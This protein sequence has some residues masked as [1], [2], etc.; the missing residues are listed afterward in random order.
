MST[1]T[2][3]I[4]SGAVGLV[5][6]TTIALG[7]VAHGAA[8]DTAD[9]QTPSID[10]QN[11]ARDHVLGA[12]TADAASGTTSDGSTQ[13]Q[14]AGGPNPRVL[15][16]DVSGYQPNVDWGS[17]YTKG[18][19]FVFI[20]ATESYNST[21]SSFTSQWK[22]ATNAG[23][24]RGAYHFAD[25]FES[26]GTSQANWFLGHGGAWTPDG[27]TLPP[28][29]DLEKNT[30]L[31][32]GDVSVNTC[33]NL[34]PAQ[35]TAW[36]RDFSNTVLARTGIRPTIYTNPDFWQTCMAGSTSFGANSLFLAHWTYDLNTGP[37]A[38]PASWS[39]YSFWQY[40]DD[41]GSPVFP[42]DQDVFN[43][44]AA[45]L[46]AFA[47]H[48]TPDGNYITALYEDYLKRA[49]APQESAGWQDR[50]A[51]GAPRTAVAAGFVNSD[52]YR[53]QRI[54]AAYQ[55]VLGRSPDAPGRLSWLNAMKSGGIT[56]DDI[57]TSL[58][59]STE[60]FQNH[61]NTN[62]SFVAS[63]YTTLLHRQGTDAD[64]TFWANLIA[65][66][67]RAWVVAQYWDA[68]E[69]ISQRVSA[70]YQL[71]LGRV[72]DAA[73]LQGWVNVALQIGDSGL[74]SG[75]TSSGEYYARSQTRTF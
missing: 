7:G 61:G 28:V 10:A 67:G 51:A 24:L 36:A 47:R 50:L 70:M 49:P 13:A 38:L 37:G 35:L 27:K 58:Y 8:A 22:G 15:G 75:F 17:A 12:T 5:I 54:D 6:A 3:F 45:A 26:S 65:Q 41:R 33:Y 19:R 66:N 29:L 4:R 59:S 57:E 73:G 18:A 68:Q 74:R 40:A 11:D 20:K 63:L 62:K 14:A 39:S 23:F 16:M 34:S 46:T 1:F 44:S 53:L 25:P 21:N 64:Y 30:Y 60:Y 42:G 31:K 48:A 72:P 52:E 2:S 9:G 71:Y 69:T 32:Y 55:T 56:T 43:G